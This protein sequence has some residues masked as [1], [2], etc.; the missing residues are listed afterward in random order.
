LIN[1]STIS[2]PGSRQQVSGLPG[3]VV[4]RIYRSTI[5]RIVIVRLLQTIPVLFGVTF[6]LF[7]LLNVLPGGTAAQILGTSV[8]PALLHALNVK[9]GLDHPF[10]IRYFHWLRLAVFHG[11]LGTSLLNGVPVASTIGQR[12]PVSA[13]IGALAFVEAM[14]LAIPV[15]IMAARKPRGVLDRLNLIV[16]MF[17]ISCPVFVL[18]LIA[19]LIFA[20]HL[21]WLPSI[22]YV[23]LSGGLWQ[24]LRTIILPSASIAFGLFAAFSRILRADLIDQMNGEDYIVTA[25]SYGLAEWVILLRH[26]FR[27]AVFNLI[28]V[29]VLYLGSIIAGAVL[30]EQIFGIPGM[31][32]LLL[33]AISYRDEPTVLGI[34]A[35]LACVVVC[36]NLLADLLYAVLD[37]RIRHGSSRV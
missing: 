18:A 14:V 21:H 23:P 24:N 7:T 25:R 16:S 26:A 36:A 5:L 13:E 27:N 9:L 3:R 29:A 20:V 30:V 34:V 8:T 11:N 2:T 19:S 37:P 6:I 4:S 15:A 28:T 31:G 10:L 33:S 17:G 22:G 32:T 35:I 12:L 1:S